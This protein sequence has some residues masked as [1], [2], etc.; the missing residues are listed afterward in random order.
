MMHC[1][2]SFLNERP[3]VTSKITQLSQTSLKPVPFC[4]KELHQPMF[5]LAAL[6]GRPKVAEHFPEVC[7]PTLMYGE[8][9]AWQLE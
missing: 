1:F 3:R 9:A 8:V 6:L 2:F 7:R 5:T 4:D